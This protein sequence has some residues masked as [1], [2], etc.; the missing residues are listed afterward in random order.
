MSGLETPVNN[1]VNLM[2]WGRIYW[3]IFLVTMLVAFLVAEIYAL[4]TGG[5]ANTLSNWVWVKLNV[6]SHEKI[7]QWSAL[8]YLMFGEWLTLVSWLTW[9]FFFRDFT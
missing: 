9:H 5:A 8:D 6:T 4:V 3:P 2:T 7:S 1:S